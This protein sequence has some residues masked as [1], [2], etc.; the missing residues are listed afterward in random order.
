MNDTFSSTLRRVYPIRTFRR[1]RTDRRIWERPIIDGRCFRGDYSREDRGRRV[2]RTNEYR[3]T[4]YSSHVLE[5]RVCCDDVKLQRHDL[6]TITRSLISWIEV[7]M[8]RIVTTLL[9]QPAN[10][11]KLEMKL[12]QLQRRFLE[13][14]SK[15]MKATVLTSRCLPGHRNCTGLLKLIA[16]RSRVS[17]PAGMLRERCEDDGD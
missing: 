6:I 14:M 5:E 1:I 4:G 2:R 7:T 16:S 10:T 15:K 17:S 11:K 12:F 13:T 8:T 3:V 9:E